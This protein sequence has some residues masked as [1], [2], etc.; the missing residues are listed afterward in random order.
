MGKVTLPKGFDPN[1]KKHWFVLANRAFASIYEGE[2]NSDFHFL[3]RI[4]NPKGDLKAAELVNDRPGRSFSSARSGVRHSLEP[5][6]KSSE[7]V[8]LQFAR[9]LARVL[10]KAVHQEKCSDLVV[11][12]EPHFLGLMNKV[13]SKKLKSMVKQKVIREWQ[14]GSDK[15]LKHFLQ[16]NL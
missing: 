10:D 9:Q 5:K 6:T 1:Q 12:A 16:E 14:R 2:L 4:N 11:V 7:A 13:F 8:A 3:T 15:D